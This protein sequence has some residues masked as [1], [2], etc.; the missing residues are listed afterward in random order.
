MV[1]AIRGGS[2]GST[3]NFA[4]YHGRLWLE[5]SCEFMEQQGLEGTTTYGSYYLVKFYRELKIFFNH[6][7][8][9]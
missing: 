9:L 8:L 2:W 3:R 6:V 1:W 7:S 5:L 4:T